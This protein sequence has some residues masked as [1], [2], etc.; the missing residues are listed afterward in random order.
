MGRIAEAIAAANADGR[1]ALVCYIT[2]GDPSLDVTA[3]IVCAVADAG[4]DVV[5]LGIPFSDPV[6]DGPTIQASSQ[7]AL[8]SGADVPS[9]LKCVARIRERCSVPIVA[10][11]YFNPILSYGCERFGEEGSDSGLDGVI[12]TDMPAEESGEWVPIARRNGLDTIMLVTPTSTQER[13]EA[14]AALATGF[15]YCVA[16]LGVTGASA[17]ISS[18]AGELV[19]RARM[20]ARCPVCLGFG[21]SSP[22]HVRSLSPLADGVVVGSALVGLL[23]AQPT[24]AM[25]VEKAAAMVA[26]LHRATLRAG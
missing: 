7:R 5:E 20:V 18:D 11:S 16:R 21:I 1:C 10:M 24:A 19:A 25:K 8:A 15:L 9:S 14:S 12:V 22:D 17:H 26:D 13:L 6:A 2:G 23:A 3:D 4:A